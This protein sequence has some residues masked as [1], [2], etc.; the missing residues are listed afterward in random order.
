MM[1]KCKEPNVHYLGY[2]RGQDKIDVLK[3][4]DAVILPFVL[5]ETCIFPCTCNF[6]VGVPVPIPILSLLP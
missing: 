6:D 5:P 3:S 1:E 4:A 2:L